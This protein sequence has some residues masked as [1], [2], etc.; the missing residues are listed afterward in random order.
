M[1]LDLVERFA[2]ALYVRVDSSGRLA[3][4]FVVDPQEQFS[5]T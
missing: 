3:I 2:R 4:D 5:G 1:Q